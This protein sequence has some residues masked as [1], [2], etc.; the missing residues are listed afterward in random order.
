MITDLTRDID[1]RFDKVFPEA[2][3]KIG[4]KVIDLAGVIFSESG[5]RPAAHNKSPGT[6]RDKVTKEIRPSRPEERYNA[7]GLIQ[8]M[9][10]TLKGLQWRDGYEA[11]KH[12]SASQQV[13]YMIAYY[14]PWQKTGAPFDSAGRLYQ[15]TFLPGTLA[16]SKAP[17]DV[18]TARGGRLGWAYEANQVFDANGDG[19]ITIGELTEAVHRNARGPRWLELLGRLGV[20]V[21]ELEAGDDDDLSAALEGGEGEI[22]VFLRSVRGV[23]LALTKLGY[24]VGEHGIDN[25]YGR[26][27]RAAVLKFQADHELAVDGRVGKI[28]RGELALALLT[29]Q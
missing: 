20:D 18:L 28:T 10:A 19:A 29:A 23:Q 4:C 27:T 6:V 15:A 9:P 13:P 22:E 11:F 5:A 26:D 3:A 24:S 1:P 12:L 7:V 2:C 21:A 25:F 14:Q 17:D 8:F 16:T